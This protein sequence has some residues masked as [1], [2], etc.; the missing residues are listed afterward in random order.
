MQQAELNKLI[1]ADIKPVSPTVRRRLPATAVA[2]LQ[3]PR[4]AV[5][6]PLRKS[7][8]GDLGENGGSCRTSVTG[9]WGRGHLLLLTYRFVR[10]GAAA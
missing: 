9:E 4:T 1:T 3:R 2:F 7:P 10:I 5:K 6:E 8:N